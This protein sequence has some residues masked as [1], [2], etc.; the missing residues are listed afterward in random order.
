[1]SCRFPERPYLKNKV[2]SEREDTSGPHTYAHKDRQT[3]RIDRP[4]HTHIESE[5]NEKLKS[6]FVLLTPEP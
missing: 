6:L 3:D 4:T 2:K 5:L 1:M